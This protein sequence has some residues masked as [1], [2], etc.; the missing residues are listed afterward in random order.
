MTEYS[1]EIVEVVLPAKDI[2][3][4]SEVKRI[5]DNSYR[6][7][8]LTDSLKIYGKANGFTG[9]EQEIKYTGK[10]M[11]MHWQG[12][13]LIDDDFNLV[14]ITSR[15]EYQRHIKFLADRNAQRTR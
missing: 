9:V 14:W 11:L 10:K 4:G 3:I 5:G 13:T 12:V 6:K 7:L 1:N 8:F 15:G 2:P